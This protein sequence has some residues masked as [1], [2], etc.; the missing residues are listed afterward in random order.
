MSLKKLEK[1]YKFSKEEL[2]DIGK[3]FHR[4]ANKN[5]EI[6]FESFRKFVGLIGFGEAEMICERLFNV[7]VQEGDQSVE[8]L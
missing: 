7:I 8:V 5:D 3:Q 2:N 6:D 4:Y 1:I